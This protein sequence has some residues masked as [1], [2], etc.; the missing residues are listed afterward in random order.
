MKYEGMNDNELV[1]LANDNNE[2]AINLLINK[3]KNIIITVLKDNKQKYNIY[4]LD[5][6]DLYQEGLLGLF[7]AIE[8]YNK[9]KDILFY[10]YASV[11]IK[12]YIMTA[13]RKTFRNK[14]KI[15]NNSYSLDLLY[16]ESNA[17]LHEVLE[18]TSSNP[19]DIIIGKETEAELIKT[20]R[21]LLTKTELTIF[22]LKLKGLSNNEI[23]S[24]MNEDKK[25]IENALYRIKRKYKDYK[26]NL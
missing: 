5:I 15:L 18:D 22:E 20:I 2:E 21:S 1:S 11:C 23:S 19:D 24:L 8:T 10:T 16:D 7:T 26:N 12:S 25:N 6:A 13:I 17:S 3:Y 4:G 14:N 9:E